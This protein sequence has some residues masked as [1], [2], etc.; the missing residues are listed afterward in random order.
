MTR[1]ARSNT[2]EAIPPAAPALRSNLRAAPRITCD[3]PTADR[4]VDLVVAIFKRAKSDLCHPGYRAGA[5][6]WLQSQHAAWYASLLGVDH[7]TVGN[8]HTKLESAA[9]IPQSTCR[10]GADTTPSTTETQS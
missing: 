2:L 8:W 9:G 3:D 6:Q 1:P 7:T 10:T 4:Y 5:Q